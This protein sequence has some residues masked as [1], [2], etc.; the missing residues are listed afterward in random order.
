MASA[1]FKKFQDEQAKKDSEYKAWE[2][3]QWKQYG[4]EWAKEGYTRNTNTNNA[5]GSTWSYIRPKNLVSPPIDIP[6]DEIEQES[7]QAKREGTGNQLIGRIQPEERAV[8]PAIETEQTPLIT[9]YEFRNNAHF[10]NHHFLKDNA[11]ITIDGKTYPIMVTTGLYN[12]NYGVENDRTYAFNPET[13]QI[14]AVFEN[15]TGMP[16][17]YWATNSEWITPGWMAGPEYEWKKAN[18]MPAMRGPLG[19]E[20]TSEY[21]QWLSNY[22]KAKKTGFK[23]QGGTMNKVEYFQ[24]GGQTQNDVQRQIEALVEA[25]ISGDQKA[26]QQVNQIM[27][28]A[29]QGDQQAAQ[30][31]QMIQIAV[32][33]L[34]G[35]ATAAKWGTK[36]QYIKSLK[37]AKG[38]KTCPE[39][40]KEDDNTVKVTKKSLV[41][42]KCGGIT[43]EKKK[44]GGVAKKRPAKKEC[45]GKAKKCYFGGWL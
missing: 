4:T 40:M 22:E 21:K 34:K 26:T 6:K 32:Q 28:A 38:G 37:F 14:R 35:Q 24:K 41:K 45:G 43:P 44:C 8:N 11:N 18:P 12:T 7:A 31:A 23:K 1:L 30:L 42:K 20:L 9:E 36:L 10:R 13:G 16:H 19:G 2:E 25:A 5:W 17:N 29:K 33:K 15:F 3:D 27:Q 39:C